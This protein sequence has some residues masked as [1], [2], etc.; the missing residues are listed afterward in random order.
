MISRGEGGECFLLAQVG[1]VFFSH[2]Q[3]G[4]HHMCIT[5]HVLQILNM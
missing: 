3:R 1:V 2:V 5:L 4:L